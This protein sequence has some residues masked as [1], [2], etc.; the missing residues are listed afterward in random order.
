MKAARLMDVNYILRAALLSINQD[1]I[2][3]YIY[4]HS[5]LN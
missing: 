1:A 2:Q 4:K 5:L 3:H